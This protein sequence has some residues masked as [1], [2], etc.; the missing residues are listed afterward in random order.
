MAAYLVGHIRVRDPVRWKEY[1]AGVPG[2]LA[3]F[4]GQVVFRGRRTSVLAGEHGHELVVVLRF[5]DRSILESWHRSPAYQA[6]VPIRDAAADVIL[7][8]YDEVS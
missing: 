2:T 7:V 6:L 8:S 3:P 4:G 5:P 1:V